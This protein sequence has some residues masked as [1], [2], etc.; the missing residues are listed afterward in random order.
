M[1][2]RASL[3][4]PAAPRDTVTAK[5]ERKYPAHVSLYLH[6]AVM[7]RI[8]VLA[9]ELDCRPHE[10]LVEGVDLML[11][12]HGQPTSATIAGAAARREAAKGLSG[13][14]ARATR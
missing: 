5:R 6:P 10:L 1:S 7:R 9:V 2:R 4:S 12:K 13:G 8:K 14:V 3:V 11:R